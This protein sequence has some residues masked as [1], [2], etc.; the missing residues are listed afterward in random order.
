MNFYQPMSWK[1]AAAS[2]KALPSLAFVISR[3]LFDVRAEQPTALS[4]AA[5]FGTALLA[6]KKK[7]V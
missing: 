1:I 5:P 2:L 3:I 7:L 6:P 4:A